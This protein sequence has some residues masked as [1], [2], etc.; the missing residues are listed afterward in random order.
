MALTTL[1]LKETFDVF[2][3][4]SHGKMEAISFSFAHLLPVKK[5]TIANKT[6]K[7]A[8]KQPFLCCLRIVA[9]F[10]YLS[11]IYF[12]DTVHAPMLFEKENLFKWLCSQY[13]WKKQH[14]IIPE[15]EFLTCLWVKVHI[16]ITTG[17]KSKLTKM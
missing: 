10:S 14:N 4:L 13:N 6:Y 7:F 16:I 15:S 3:F 11:F 8:T 1:W 12:F 5:R 9:V 2:T 17:F